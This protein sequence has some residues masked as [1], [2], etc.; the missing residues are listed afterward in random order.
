MIGKSASGKDT[1]FKQ[2]LSNKRPNLIPVTPY[3]TRPKRTD[4]KSGVDYHF[5]TEEQ[6]MYFES[7]NR[8]I[9]KRQ[10]HTTQGLWRYFT[11]KFNIEND[12]NYILITTLEGAL[13]IA[14]QYGSDMVHVVYLVADDKTRLLRCIDR[15]SRQILPDYVEVC[16]RFIADQKDFSDEKIR[17]LKNVHRID[18]SLSLEDCLKKWNK[19]YDSEG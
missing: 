10:Y 11:L 18:T 6:L 5:V 7:E 13:S 2:I 4:E 9:E 19:L 3:T 15:E 1:L 17:L 14:E 16:R 8:V 12:N